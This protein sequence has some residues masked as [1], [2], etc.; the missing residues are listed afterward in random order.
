MRILGISAFYHDSAACLLE[1]GRLVAAAQEER[2][3]RKRHDPG[4]PSMA[5]DYCLK[6]AGVDLKGVDAI[7]YYE[8]PFLKFERIL[9]TVVE[10]SPES[11]GFGIKAL[12]VWIKDKL[13]MRKRIWRELGAEIPVYFTDHHES[14][15]A[16]AY[17]PSPFDKAA[18]L[19]VDG[20]GEAST[21][22]WGMG[23]GNRLTL[24]EEIRYP[25]SLGLLY[26]AL[27]QYLGFKV[28][29]AEYKVMGLAP[30]GEPKYVDTFWKNLVER[31]PDGSYLLNMEYFSFSKR[32]EMINEKFDKLFG[33]SRRKEE[34]IMEPFHADVARSLQV[35]TEELMLGL[36][37]YVHEKSGMKNLC[38]AG[39][40]ALNCVANGRIVREG[41]FENVWIQPGAGDS[42]GAVGAAYI[43]WHHVMNESR[44]TSIGDR[45]LGSLLGPSYTDE[46]A[47][48]A[49]TRYGLKCRRLSAND[50]FAQTAEF[51]GDQK[52]V[53]WFQGRMGF[54][55]RALGAR[56]IL[57]DARNAEMQ[58]RMNLKIK[59]R[60]SFRP[61]AP[62]VLAEDA[63]DYFSMDCDSPYMLLTFGVNEKVGAV[64]K[65]ATAGNR[66]WMHEMLEG[67]SG[68]VPAVTH[69][70]GSARVQTV[71][72]SRNRP[73]YN[74]LKEFK[75][76]TG[77]S[78]LI[79]TSFNVRGEPIVCT[80]NDAV[81]CF[82]KSDIDVLVVGN[83]IATR[84][85]QDESS[86][87]SLR[88]KFTEEDQFELD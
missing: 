79:N 72:A 14:H 25:N 34:S 53:G 33:Q 23:E 40:V 5:I 83:V 59:F 10:N 6:E 29:S 66:R 44:P 69:V 16:S 8:K 41:P 48:Q 57:G 63:K 54:G 2:F 64:R 11:F 62:A 1:D 22:T 50:C 35:V 12:P 43:V 76:K 78:V 47:E 80:P 30:Y 7:A 82:V 60:E 88:K 36:S 19:T 85:E 49:F 73:F 51:L 24:K 45:Q 17:F 42:G 27:T 26:S 18:T 74:L 4:F 56:S 31:F 77:S 70:D 46:E 55:P 75:R 67:N 38:L 61:F 9:E 15:A 52:I 87:E 32:L 28:N 13:W 86:L 3:T 71:D 65:V 20:V 84:T 39:G 58:K 81:R 21:T 37:R 68:R